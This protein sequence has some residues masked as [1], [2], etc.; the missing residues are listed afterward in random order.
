MKVKKKS[1]IARG[2]LPADADLRQHDLETA[3][4]ADSGLRLLLRKG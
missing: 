1:P 4:S 3:I 2:L